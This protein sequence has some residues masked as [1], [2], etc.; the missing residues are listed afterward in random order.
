MRYYSSLRLLILNDFEKI[1]ICYGLGIGIG[2]LI[3]FI[4]KTNREKDDKLKDD[5]ISI[6]DQNHQNFTR[7][8]ILLVSLF[9]LSLTTATIRLKNQKEKRKNRKHTRKIFNSSLDHVARGGST[10]FEDE[11]AIEVYND[12]GM[13]YNYENIEEYFGLR[14][15]YETIFKLKPIFKTVTDHATSLV[16]IVFEQMEKRKTT[17]ITCVQNMGNSNAILLVNNN[18]LIER[19]R[20]A[21]KL[22]EKA[23]VGITPALLTTIIRHDSSFVPIVLENIRMNL[24]NTKLSMGIPGGITFVLGL[25]TKLGVIKFAISRTQLVILLLIGNFIFGKLNPCHDFFLAL[26]PDT[27]ETLSNNYKQVLG[28]GGYRVPNSYNEKDTAP[29]LVTPNSELIFDNKFQYSESE[30][31]ERKGN[32]N[33]KIGL[34]NSVEDD[35]HFLK[36]ETLGL[37]DVSTIG[38]KSVNNLVKKNF[39]D[40]EP[41][42]LKQSEKDLFDN[43]KLNNQNPKNYRVHVPLSSKKKQ[44]NRKMYDVKDLKQ[45]S[46]SRMREEE[47]IDVRAREV[48]EEVI[49]SEKVRVEN[50]KDGD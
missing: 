25:L 3:N 43:L 47:I 21:L 33:E 26:T 16:Q 14:L 38:D 7:D 36:I 32:V 13:C 27:I 19:I 50:K 9:A 49:K 30:I 45:E 12:K 40:F 37:A 41:I 4:L 29:V 24:S 35:R 28:L 11:T 8:R 46:K 18:R 2:A 1:I 44:F 31:N 5:D 10:K 17:S 34:T 15:Y 48:R 6:N 42:Q 22:D 39:Q 20:T 23:I